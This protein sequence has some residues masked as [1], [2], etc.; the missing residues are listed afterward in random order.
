[1]RELSLLEKSLSYECHATDIRIAPGVDL[2]FKQRACWY[3]GDVL[4]FSLRGGEYRV[5]VSVDKPAYGNVL[6]NNNRW[7]HFY[8]EH[9][10]SEVMKEIGIEADSQIDYET[11]MSSSKKTPLV[12]MEIPD[13]YCVKVTRKDGTLAYSS[14][15][16]GDLMN[17]LLLA[18]SIIEPR[19]PEEVEDMLALM[20]TPDHAPQTEF[21]PPV[22]PYKYFLKVYEFIDRTT[23]GGRFYPGKQHETPFIAR[24]GF[25]ELSEAQSAFERFKFDTPVTMQGAGTS[26]TVFHY[27]SLEDK[28]GNVIQTYLPETSVRRESSKIA[29]KR[30]M[31]KRLSP[32]DV[33]RAK[34]SRAHELETRRNRM[35]QNAFRLMDAVFDFT[36]YPGVDLDLRSLNCWFSGP[37]ITLILSDETKVTVSCTRPEAGYIRTLDGRVEHYGLGGE[38]AFSDIAREERLVHNLELSRCDVWK[39][40]AYT[41]TSWGFSSAELVQVRTDSTAEFKLEAV[42]RDGNLLYE[43]G[44]FTEL[45]EAFYFVDCSLHLIDPNAQFHRTDIALLSALL[46][47]NFDQ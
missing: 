42:D 5:S 46:K 29:A 19:D 17:V 3:I 4:S 33:P 12:R 34:K 8:S 37:I 1:M 30:M 31:K 7:I 13:K 6:V 39:Q 41:K 32:L 11:R 24:Y 26:R 15:M 38:R 36:F 22:Y 2:S 21:E 9:P 16:D 27:L 44:G 35:I 28:D 20:T 43:H 25:T 47:G 14:E 23:N 45:F 10:F 40:L 18:K